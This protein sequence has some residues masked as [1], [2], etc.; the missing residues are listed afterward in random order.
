MLCTKKK[1]LMKELLF[2]IPYEMKRCF[3][4]V[5]ALYSPIIGLSNSVRGG[6]GESLSV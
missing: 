1:K 5:A 2:L 4:F 6:A 3:D